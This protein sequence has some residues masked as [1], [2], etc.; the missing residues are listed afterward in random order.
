MECN[1]ATVNLE[2]L[3][4][5]RKSG[6]NRLSIGAQSFDDDVLRKLG[7]VHR[8]EDVIKTVQLARKAGF[9]N[10]SLDL[11]FS[12]P[13]QDMGKWVESMKTVS[14]THLLKAEGAKCSSTWEHPPCLRITPRLWKWI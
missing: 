13:G 4:K 8:A 14:Y 2:K 10:I 3:V 9:D 12:V 11:M 1:P 7:R 5:Y 6:V